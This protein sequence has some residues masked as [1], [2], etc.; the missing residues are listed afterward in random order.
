M[1]LWKYIHYSP[2]THEIEAGYPLKQPWI[3]D[4]VSPGAEYIEEL[5]DA[6]KIEHIKEPYGQREADGLFYFRQIRAEIVLDY[7]KGN[8]SIDDVFGIEAKLREVNYIL[9]LGD[10]LT[11]QNEL[12]SVTVTPPLS[13][14]LYDQI[15]NHMTQYISDNY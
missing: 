10:W 9:I 11:A 4:T 15:N 12:Q 8:L 7:Y 6:V 14:A 2:I 13:Q 3:W 5:D 1:K